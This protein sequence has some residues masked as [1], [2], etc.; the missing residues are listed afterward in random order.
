[1]T[2]AAQLERLPLFPLAQVVL[3]PQTQVPLHVF[4]PR[5]RQMIED[6]LSSDRRIGM[7]AVPPEYVGEMAGDPPLYTVGCAGV[8]TSPER[9]EDGRFRFSLVGSQRFRVHGELPR[10]EGLLYRIAEVELLED[11]GPPPDS[12]RV[13]KLRETVVDLVGTLVSR[14]R[15]GSAEALEHL[16]TR[17]AALDAGAFTD[18]LCQSLGFGT[19]E[20]QG[21]LE[22]EG[23]LQRL[24]QLSAVL[25]FHLAERAANRA[26]RSVH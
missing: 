20:K 8:I 7:I 14:T 10:A 13:S 23:T 21:L 24:E 18:A 16:T 4:E 25:R 19:P 17:L 2:P 22:A 1:V 12:S 3:F 9:L 11:A 6:A 26:P 5:Y 15:P